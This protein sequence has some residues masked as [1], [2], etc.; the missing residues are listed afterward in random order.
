MK[1]KKEQFI[2]FFINNGGISFFDKNAKAKYSGKPST[3]YFNWR[4]I[5][6]DV[7]NLEKCANYVISYIKAKK[8]NPDCFLGVPEGASKL[9]VIMQYKWARTSGKYKKGSHIMALARGNSKKH[10]MPKDRDFLGIPKRKVFL[11]EDIASRG[12]A[13]ID[14]IKKLKKV[15]ITPYAVIVLSDRTNKETKTKL[16]KFLS[17]KKIRYYAITN[18]KEVVEKAVEI[19]KP[20]KEIINKLK[21]RGKIK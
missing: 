9:A 18:Q 4:T 20:P 7:Y 11:I 14:I 2:K 16:L 19:L 5:V 8:L 13:I 21:E 6:E 12:G 10:G 17:T 15:N 3:I 1:F